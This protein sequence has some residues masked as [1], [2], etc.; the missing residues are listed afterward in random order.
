MPSPFPGMNPYLEQ[1]DVWTDFHDRLIPA[2]ADAL[3]AQVDPDYIVRIQEQLYIHEPAAETRRLIGRGDISAARGEKRSR[4]QAGTAI[5]KAPAK[6]EL[7]EVDMERISQVEVRDRL[8]RQLVTVIEVLSPTNK[9]ASSDRDQYLSKRSRLLRSPVHLVEID[10]LRGGPRM[11]AL[12][13]P[14]CEYC[15]LVSRHHERPEADIWP[16]RLRDVLPLIPVPLHSPHPDAQLDLQ[17]LLHRIYDA[18]HYQ[19]SIYEGTPSPALSKKDAAWA[20]QLLKP[21]RKKQKP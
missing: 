7:A 14:E 18:A 21:I 17:Q 20:E 9:Y 19:T 10:L 12:N 4:A 3:V 11:P 2:I 8:N 5:L 1:A 6:V 15:V 16:L 13:M